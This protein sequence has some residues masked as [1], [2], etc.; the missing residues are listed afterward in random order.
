MSFLRHIRACNA[1][2]PSAY[3]P[4]LVD[5]R[6]LGF[7]SI[8]LARRLE[9]F[10]EIFRVD[11]AGLRFAESLASFDARTE[12]VGELAVRLAE[13][14]DVRPLDGEPYAAVTS[15]GEPPAFKVDR[16]LVPALGLRSYGVHVNGYVETGPAAADKRMWIGRRAD[17]RRVAPG[18]LD[19]LIGGGQPF[20]LSLAEN[21]RKEGKEEAGLGPDI[22]DQ[23]RPAGAV[24]YIMAQPDGL[25][26]DTLFVYDL[27]LD[28]SV[29]P[30]NED[31][32]VAEFSCLPVE[33][34]IARVRD[35]DDFKFNVPLVI[36]DFLIR[37]GILTPET[38]DYL[39][40]VTDLR[41]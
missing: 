1:H 27:V 19:N 31:G 36:I 13:A 21:L 16:A 15:W 14:G 6:A 2:D 35:T 28:A 29:R 4:L 9:A 25:R 34:V 41:R 11:P 26:R 22:V 17:D 32:E 23:A 3:R 20:G 8:G 38:P 18:R 40:L 30:R 7:V 10:S 12:A 5:G 37:H 39:K 24:S 33:E